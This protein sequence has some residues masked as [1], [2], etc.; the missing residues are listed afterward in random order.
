MSPRAQAT[1]GKVKRQLISPAKPRATNLA[2]SVSAV[3]SRLP[4]W[5]DSAATCTTSVPRRAQLRAV[6]PNGV[7]AAPPTRC[8]APYIRQAAITAPRRARRF[9]SGQISNLAYLGQ[10]HRIAHGRRGWVGATLGWVPVVG[11]EWAK[12]RDRLHLREGGIDA[13]ASRG[14]VSL[15]L[16][17]FHGPPRHDPPQNPRSPARLLPELPAPHTT[18]RAR[19]HAR[20]ARDP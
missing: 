8:L 15:V 1:L 9:R 4:V 12:A 6:P 11:K 13:L 14:I 7:L 19:P 3:P 16:P 18:A 2:A 10:R 5:Y 17:A 20:A